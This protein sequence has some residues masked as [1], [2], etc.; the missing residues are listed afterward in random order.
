MRKILLAIFGVF[1]ASST[2]CW[3]Q[4]RKPNFIVILADDL[5][6]K[7]L[8][9]YGNTE[10]K[11]PNLDAL[12]KSGM[13]FET[14]WATP[15]CSPSRVELM[16]GR[17]AFRTGWYSLIGRKL[18]PKPDSPQ[19]DI[20]TAQVT[21]ADLVK[22]LGYTTALSGKWQLSGKL[23]TLINDCG[24]DKYCMWAYADDLPDDEEN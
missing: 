12:A 13:R 7:E 2:L 4:A 9:C 10:N 8:G 6:A 11:T 18:S 15:L 1:L 17:Y 21:F 23:P 3:G 20:G 5:G 14:C 24:F 22:P 19:F 16:T